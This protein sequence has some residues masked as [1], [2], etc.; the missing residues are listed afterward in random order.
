MTNRDRLYEMFG[1]QLVEAL[2]LIIKDEINI[3]RTHTG[4][5]ERT[6]QQLINAIDN[7]LANLQSYD[8]MEEE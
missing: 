8:W 7:K 6:T 2:A 3:L 5:S 1:P 4:L